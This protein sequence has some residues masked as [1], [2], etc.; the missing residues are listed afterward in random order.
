[1]RQLDGRI[2]IVGDDGDI[3]LQ[4][5]LS[6]VKNVSVIKPGT[7]MIVSID[8]LHDNFKNQLPFR[9]PARTCVDFGAITLMTGN[10][11]ILIY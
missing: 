9:D 6:G 8:K 1:M 7:E 3:V 2:G 5:L 10:D 4:A 11:C